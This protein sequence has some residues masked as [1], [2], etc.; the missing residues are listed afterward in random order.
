MVSR[1]VFCRYVIPQDIAHLVRIIGEDK[2]CVP[3]GVLILLGIRLQDDEKRWKP[4]DYF[5]EVFAK[6]QAFRNELTWKRR[7]KSCEESVEWSKKYN[8]AEW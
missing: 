3:C 2:E 1:G 5:G 4:R 7:G 8:E 6:E